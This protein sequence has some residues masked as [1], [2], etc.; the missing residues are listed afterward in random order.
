MKKVLSIYFIKCIEEGGP[1]DLIVML[2][3]E[4]TKI[5]SDYNQFYTIS[6]KGIT[7]YVNEEPVE[8]ITLNDWLQD[9]TN[10]NKI[11]KKTFFQK[12][13]RWKVLR[14]WRRKIC[15][16]KREKVTE[17]LQDKLFI[18]HDVFS[19]VILNQRKRCIDVE[20]Q[21]FLHLP[22]NHT[23]IKREDFVKDQIKIRDNL[24][25]K[26]QKFSRES[27]SDFMQG[28]SDII[29]NLQNK[30]TKDSDN[31]DTAKNNFAQE[32]NDQKKAYEISMNKDQPNAM[33]TSDADRV[34]ENLGF[35][36]NLKYG[37]KS[38]LR[39]ECSRFLRFSY[40]L[41]FVTMDALR[42][43]YLNSV[44]FLVDKLNLLTHIKIDFEFDASKS[45][46]GESKRPILSGPEPLFIL[47]GDFKDD[48]I[49]PG[50]MVE[51][52][53]RKFNPPPVGNST[54]ADFDPIAHLE[55]EEK[56]E[57][58]PEE[59][60]DILDESDE[61]SKYKTKLICPNIHK[62]WI[63]LDPTKTNFIELLDESI[64]Q[65]YASLKVIERWSRSEEL[66]KY[67]KV[68]ESW[69]YKVCD[70]WEP[71]DDNHLDCDS[72]LESEEL[73][74]DQKKIIHEFMDDAFDKA[75][76]YI[77]NFKPYLQIYYDN[78]HINYDIIL[79]E[80]LK[81][82]Q[83]VIPELLKRL[84]QQIDDFDNYLPES[85]DLGLLR[86]DFKKCK[87]KI[88]PS[89]KEVFDKVKKEFPLVI[90]RRIMSKKNWLLD[91]I[92]SITSAVIDVDQFVK[93]VQALEFIDKHFQ[94]VKDEIDLYQNLQR[95]CAQNGIPISKEDSKLISEIYQIISN[96]SQSVMDTADSID[97]KKK[98]NIDNIRKKIP[99]FQK[100]VQ[101]FREK[102][103]N[104][105]YLDIKNSV[106]TTLDDM[107]LLKRE[108]DE[109]V[110][111]S[112]KYQEWQVTLDMEVNQFVDVDEVRREVNDRISLWS[113]IKDW[114]DKVNSWIN[115]PFDSIDTET[116]SLE[117]DK[118]TKTVI[119]CERGL[120]DGNS[121]VMHLKKKVFEF[122]DTM[123]IVNALGNKELQPDHWIEI[124][125]QVPGIDFE[126]EKKEFSL[127]Q[128]IDI[129]IS[130]YQEV[131]QNISIK[132]S[133]EASLRRQ[134][135]NIKAIWESL[136]F[137]T[138]MY[139][140]NVYILTELDEIQMQLDDS[141]TN[142]NNVMGNRY[143][144]KHK[145]E[146]AELKASL[147]LFVEIFDQWKECQRN[148]LYLE[149]IFL[150]EDIKQQTKTDYNEFEKVNKRIMDVMK[151]V[152]KDNRV[153][154]YAKKNLLK[155]LDQNNKSM[156]EI[157]RN[158]EAFLEKKR[159]DFPRFF[160]LSNDE[161]LQI[162]AA[163]QDIHKV[164]K[165]LSKIFENIVKLKLGEDMNSNQIYSFIS[166][167]NEIV[168][169]ISNIK[170]RTEEN[171]EYTLKEIESRMYETL[172]RKFSVIYNDYDYV[173]VDRKE[174]VLSEI[175]QVIT[176]I[177]QIIW[178]EI[179]ENFINDME[180]SRGLA[181]NEWLDTLIE[182]LKE[183]TELI[184]GKLDPVKRR[185]LISLITADVHNRD[186]VK[187]LDEEKVD[188]VEDFEWQKQLKYYMEEDQCVVRQ[189]NSTLKYGY[190][191]MGAASRLV[192]TPLTDRCWITITGALN[193]K[194]GAA[195]A[196]PAGTGKTESTKDLA[197]SL[198]VY[199]VVFNCS[200]Q[201]NY[202]MMGRLFSG[203]VSQ[204]AW[205]C[206]D[207]FNR[208][209][210]E[211]LSVIAQQLLTIR[212][213][214]LR[215]DNKFEFMDSEM[216]LKPMCGVFVT[217]NPG[218]EGRTELP[219]NLAVLFRP[220]AM[221]IPNY[222]L[223][224]EIM[225]FAEGFEDASSLS[226]K[227]VQLYKLASEQLSQQKHYDF[228]MRAVKSVLVMAG[229][230]KREN[231]KL[232]ED[233]VLIRAMRDSNIP[234]FL[235][236]DLPLF[237]ALIQDLFPKV[238]IPEVDYGE[239]QAQIIESC[240]TYKLEPKDEFVLKTIQLFDIINVRFGAM[241]VG[242]T[243]GGKTT[244]Y[245]LLS[246]SMTNLRLAKKSLDQRFQ[247]VHVST[248]N[249]KSITMGELYG[250]ENPDTKEWTDGLASK[251]LRENAK[252]E[253]QTRRWCIFDGPV[254]AVWIENMNSVLDDSQTLCLA[255]GERIKLRAE[256]RILFETKDLAVASP[257]TVSRCGMVY[258][259]SED[260]GWV[261]YVNS[262][263]KRMFSERED[264]TKSC[265]NP[266][267]QVF[268]RE[269]FDSYV[270]DS[271]DKLDKLAEF[272]PMQTHHIQK[273]T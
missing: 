39:K 229:A 42:N 252:D 140:D 96:L 215:G 127:G 11:R 6:K 44:Q 52:K 7:T 126:L 263:M 203:L 231:P 34:Y 64:N 56:K 3:L 182:Q 119:R 26:L 171:V 27:K 99:M 72:W 145:K 262:W 77:T 198:G 90:K 138:K 67:A 45:Q 110:A 196:G 260:L 97:H 216:T 202:K 264:G 240:K 10:Y 259:T 121:A 253:S 17:I 60:V 249:P 243:G 35:K 103:Q 73:R 36:P 244:C 255:N 76:K 92:D 55:I 181:L 251:I 209:G 191:Y 80:K 83:E 201:I 261:P 190:E 104:P 165:H 143:I 221:M 237:K 235:A 183:I 270:D 65:G 15:I 43:I 149:N 164:E 150:S 123:P 2:E 247:E 108:C 28:I 128:L 129:N 223:I 29:K 75:D 62:L 227:M 18:L 175:G 208:I 234:K 49:R 266:E 161:L 189:V 194:L 146:G 204:G 9:Q 155:E 135:D 197:K 265:L 113:A 141:L 91:R 122:K 120:P 180:M 272:E 30:I 46:F 66:D 25:E 167:E 213:A 144:A 68:L 101:K 230:L 47:D 117:A 16:Q 151:N 48:P 210:E 224:A 239:L 254:D 94:D 124:K 154:S 86:I 41:D 132:A 211:V 185:I 222:G 179:T 137:S 267:A 58:T 256:M 217:M 174:W 187:T 188:N 168:K 220:V 218:Y 107:S 23:A 53:I 178:T 238:S 133:Q 21:R 1:Y 71:P 111:I 268:L 12:F 61:E 248:L 173:G 153:K 32:E 54:S 20:N 13:D 159:Q 246:H 59:E 245:T 114:Q 214:L 192:I 147:D 88:K 258:M 212:F 85:K 84:N 273:I 109:L 93:Q 33:K 207:E 125:N 81:N 63:K 158:L 233:V 70:E 205:A 172:R 79:H 98:N 102:L 236:Q 170:I 105:R 74:V 40:L 177:S 139:K 160:F 69:D 31:E 206:L 162:L 232:Q 100:D 136:E 163:A 184:R 152:T 166:G 115:A 250:Q 38:N 195:P 116:I 131:I 14:M 193:I 242:P 142:I 37:G 186:I 199:C 200:E 8:F 241:I 176:S 106:D 50:D 82:P 4:D 156:E 95:I 257:A 24:S 225:L 134:L 87:Q 89:P 112:K 228:G 19:K 22:D 51:I 269:L 118:Y 5:L 169:F 271:L 78:M 157:Q 226:T 57:Y 219:D 148:W 130:E